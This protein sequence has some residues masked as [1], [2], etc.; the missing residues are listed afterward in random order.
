M[1]GVA[2]PDETNQHHTMRKVRIELTTLGLW[3]L[4]ATN[5]AISAWYGRINFWLIRTLE[6]FIDIGR[7]MSNCKSFRRREL[8]PG[9]PR[10]R[11]KYWPL[12]HSGSAIHWCPYHSQLNLLCCP[13]EHA[14]CQRFVLSMFGSLRTAPDGWLH[15][16]WRIYVIWGCHALGTARQA[17]HPWAR[18]KKKNNAYT[19]ASAGNRT[20]VTSMATMYSTTRP[21][22]LLTKSFRGG[23]SIRASRIWRRSSAD[24]QK[25]WIS[26]YKG[27]QSNGVSFNKALPLKVI[28]F[29]WG[30]S[31]Y[32]NSF[33][34]TGFP[35]REYF[36]PYGLLQGIV[37][38]EYTTAVG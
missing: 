24:P 9:L 18:S 29:F 25:Q 19:N 8:N 15:G 14:S 37:P 1:R 5:C 31:F 30:L 32:S 38:D 34:I 11:R 7:V 22:M 17:W 2:S 21:L 26:H 13:C 12:Y 28:C 4:R 27:F 10:D 3:D 33:R 6:I 16:R 35:F 36:P 20:R 23:N